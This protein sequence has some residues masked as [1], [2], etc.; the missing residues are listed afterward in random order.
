MGRIAFLKALDRLLGPPL[1]RLLALGA[2]PQ[3]P[4]PSPQPR[5]PG[6]DPVLVIRPGGIGDAVVLLPSLRAL[7]EALPK[8]TRIDIL[9]E[10]RNRAVFDMAALPNTRVLLYTHHPLTLQ[11]RLYRAHYAAVLDTEQSHYFS[12]IFTA[13]AYAPVRIGFDTVP[14]RS[15]LYTRTV[16]YDMHGSEREQFAK[17]LRATG[18]PCGPAGLATGNT[19]PRTPLAN[20]LRHNTATPIGTEKTAAP[21]PTGSGNGVRGNVFPVAPQPPAPQPP[22]PSPRPLAALHVGG[23][24]PSKHWPEAHYAALCDALATRGYTTILL[25]SRADT[26]IAE[27]I[28]SLCRSSKP[29]NLVGKLSLADTAARCAEAALFIGPDSGIAHLAEAAGTFSIVLFGSG[30]PAKWGPAPGHGVAI[31]ATSATSATSAT[32]A[33]PATSLGCPCSRF[34]TLHRHPHCHYECMTEITV[35]SVL[36]AIPQP[37]TPSP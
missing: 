24:N 35:D 29:E 25:G 26:A 23:S 31:T 36:A 13:W 30:D 8:E 33:T 2:T 18:A 32:P 34:G 37:L 19:F 6:S 5:E 15:R 22:A 10:P 14:A 28:L 9:C 11:Y 3:P 4:P 16:P 21:L 20:A 1:A 12:A 7:R 27:R 17:L